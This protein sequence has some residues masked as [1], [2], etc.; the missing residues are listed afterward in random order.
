MILLIDNYDSFTYNL[1]QLAGD[2]TELMIVRN[3]SPTLMAYAEKAEGIIISPGPGTPQEIEPVLQVIQR[4]YK[5]K[6]I[7]G[8]CLG[9]QAIGAA[10]GE[11]VRQAQQVYHGKTST[12]RKENGRLFAGV[13]E[14]FSVI[15]Y[16]SLVI[17]RTA[18]LS[19]FR[20]VAWSEEDQEIMAIEHRHY[21]LFGI[22]F[23][24]ESIGTKEG[25]V[26]LANFIQLCGGEK[27]E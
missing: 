7:L 5:E 23:H 21:P 18:K 25:P 8:I 4:F 11:T 12:I 13:S 20:V 16:H 22:Q 27:H 10:F 6:P 9:H 17:D 19:D 14:C 2:K 26:M 3:D 1:V 24:P 15:R